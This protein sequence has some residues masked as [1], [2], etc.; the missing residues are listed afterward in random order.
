MTWCEWFITAQEERYCCGEMAFHKLS[1]DLVFSFFKMIICVFLILY[2]K[3]FGHTCVCILCVYVYIHSFL[4][5]Y[6][7]KYILIVQNFA[8]Q[9]V[10]YES[11]AQLPPRSVLE[12]QNLSAHPR[13]TE[14]KSAFNKISRLFACILRFEKHC[15]RI[16]YIKENRKQYHEYYPSM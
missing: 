16:H 1:L 10:G 7:F 5:V 13:P 11:G 12:M 6:S 8:T 9:K 2:I 4:C 14:S 15:V 3:T